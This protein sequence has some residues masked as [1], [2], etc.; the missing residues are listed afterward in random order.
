[1]VTPTPQRIEKWNSIINDDEV[2]R[3]PGKI[4]INSFPLMHWNVSN[5]DEMDTQIDPFG[6]G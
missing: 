5:N 2:H 6:F 1:M 4:A 3:L